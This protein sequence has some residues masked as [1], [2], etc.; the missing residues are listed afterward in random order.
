MEE[1]HLC[2]LLQ[3]RCALLEDYQLAL[4]HQCGD[5]CTLGGQFHRHRRLPESVV[6]V[7]LGYMCVMAHWVV[8]QDVEMNRGTVVR[9]RTVSSV[10]AFEGSATL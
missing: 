10:L 3:S 7:T 8:Q 5:P 2:R 1:H 9:K 6:N 4:F